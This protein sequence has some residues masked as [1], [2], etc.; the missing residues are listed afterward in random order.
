MKLNC[1]SEDE[2]KSININLLLVSK[3][4]EGYIDQKIADW[5]NKNKQNITL[6]RGWLRIPMKVILQFFFDPLINKTINHLDNL[7]KENSLNNISYMFLVGGFSES[8]IF[9]ERLTDHFKNKGIEVKI[10]IRTSFAV[11]SGAVQFGLRPNAIT[12]RIAP[13]SFGIEM[14]SSWNVVKHFGGSKLE[15][16]GE[17]YCSNTFVSL[18]QKDQKIEF[19]KTITKIGYPWSKHSPIVAIKVYTSNKKIVHLTSDSNC[20]YVGDI[21]LD[22]PKM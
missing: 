16:N 6:N 1:S 18:I 19:G 5:N 13:C 17:I 12:S 22:L 3:T 7:I 15:V 2:M 14:T 21:E 11:I 9:Q 8:L 10:P 4:G 20:I